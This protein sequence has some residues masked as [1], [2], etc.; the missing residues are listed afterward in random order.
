M[1][2]VLEGHTVKRFDGE[3]GHLHYLILEMG[4]LVLDQVRTSLHALVDEDTGAARQVLER[5]MRVTELGLR[6]DEELVKVIAKRGPVARDLRA[7]VSFSKAVSDLERI[8]ENAQRIA[9]AALSMYESGSNVPSSALLRDVTI[10]GALG[11]E[12][13]EA[14]LAL[15]DTLDSDAAENLLV[16]KRE[17]D[18]EFQSCLRRLSTFILEDARLVGHSIMITLV[19]RSL[20]RIGDH[21]QNLAEY[22]IYLMRGEDVRQRERVSEEEQVIGGQ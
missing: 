14:G 1:H 16:K 6:V 8:D 12:K 22:V 7:V 4:G 15:L 13:L 2:K 11:V 19:L 5:E 10:M 21:A 20:E 3:L 9:Q 17:L 18:Q